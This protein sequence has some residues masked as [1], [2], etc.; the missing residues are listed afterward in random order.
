MRLIPAFVLLAIITMLAGCG[1]DPESV[2]T[3]T[4]QGAPEGAETDGSTTTATWITP[5]SSF[6]V[7][8]WGSSSCPPVPTEVENTTS[9]VTVI[10]EE[11]SDQVCTADMAP[12]THEFTLP[13]GTRSENVSIEVKGLAEPST[14]VL[15]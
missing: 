8:T 5:G 10:F 14:V 3:K 13:K 12:T 15:P 11:A 4:F 2:A 1:G 9:S 6:A 7:T